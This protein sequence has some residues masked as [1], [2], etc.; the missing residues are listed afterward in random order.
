LEEK[1][2]AELQA[3]KERNA[4]NRCTNKMNIEDARNSLRQRNKINKEE[5]ELDLSRLSQ[6]FE[7]FLEDKLHSNTIKYNRITEGKRMGKQRVNSFHRERNM[8]SLNSYLSKIKKEK[9]L[10]RENNRR[11]RDH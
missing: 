5:L 2:R 1:R 7:Q 8:E 9:S 3:L 10:K 4:Q 11:I 6:R